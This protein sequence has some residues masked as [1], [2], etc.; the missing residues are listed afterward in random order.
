MHVT[1]VLR[2]CGQTL[3]RARAALMLCNNH[4]V[5]GC[6]VLA[7]RCAFLLGSVSGSDGMEAY[8]RIGPP[9]HHTAALREAH[10]Q[11]CKD[12]ERDRLQV[13]R[14]LPDGLPLLGRG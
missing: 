13:S 5:R 4:N 3:I 12:R 11:G 1:D 9:A 8:S 7:T 2:P 6:V 10:S 14:P